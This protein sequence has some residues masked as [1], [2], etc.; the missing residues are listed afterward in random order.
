MAKNG[1]TILKEFYYRSE[2]IQNDSFVMEEYKKFAREYKCQYYKCMIGIGDWFIYR[3]VNRLLNYK[4]DKIVAKKMQ[5][6]DV[7]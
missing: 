4:L 6:K 3:V 5:I 1:A 7:F 2:Q